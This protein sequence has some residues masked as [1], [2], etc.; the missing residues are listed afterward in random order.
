MTFIS[1]CLQYTCLALYR[2]LYRMDA[3][4]Y[5]PYDVLLLIAL[6]ALIILE[7]NIS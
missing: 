3:P 1:T 6:F 5:A 4:I 2:R 7:D